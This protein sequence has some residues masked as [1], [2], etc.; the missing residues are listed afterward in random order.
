MSNQDSQTVL[1]K[2]DFATFT[3][4]NSE[5]ILNLENISNLIR[6]QPSGYEH[7]SRFLRFN[8]PVIEANT[9][10]TSLEQLSCSSD[11][12]TDVASCNEPRS[13]AEGCYLFSLASGQLS[14][15]PK[16]GWV[17]GTGRWEKNPGT[18]DVDIFLA[19]G[20]LVY[21]RNLTIRF[22]ALGR[23]VLQARHKTIEL[24][25][26]PLDKGESRLLGY[27]NLVKIG[28]LLYRFAYILP[29]EF[30]SDFQKTKIGFLQEHMISKEAPHELTSATPSANDAKIGDWIVHG[31]VGLS[32]SSSVDAASNMRTGEA[33]AVKRLRRSDLRSVEKVE[34]EV[35]IYE[36]LKYLEKSKNGRFVMRM[37]S[38]LYRFG[39]NWPGT[40]E[41]VF[42]LWSPLARGTFRQ[43]EPPGKWSDIADGDRLQ[44]FYQACLGLQAVHEAGWIHRDIKPHN[45]YVVS[46]SPPWAIVGDFGDAVKTSPAGLIAEPG[47][48]GTIGWLAPELENPLFASRYTQ[49]VDVWSM[50]AVGCFLFVGS[51][52][53]WDSRQAS[54]NIFRFMEDL[55]N[56]PILQKCRDVMKSLTQFT[57]RSIQNLIYRML[58]GRPSKRIDITGVLRHPVFTDAIEST[59]AS[60]LAQS[61]TG[62]KRAAD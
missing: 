62:D 39:K 34:K 36:A 48:H 37:H 53:P 56:D 61:S 24:D 59:R 18:A 51:S 31:I 7:H 25:G 27:T 21:P 45:L 14:F 60:S 28:P 35:T 19:P 4:I 32:A 33:V 1:G 12:T 23:M 29:K 2:L 15:N 3:P 9:A 8:V 54:R 50:G 16:L 20:P 13:T 22:D 30:E 49:A 6:S 41:D 46:L 52:M 17:V 5:A 47:G 43:L 11:A 58:A 40:S 55:D 44:L 57:T 38:V 26:E 42:L 10:S